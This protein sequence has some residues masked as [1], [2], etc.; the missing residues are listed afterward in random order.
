VPRA[1]YLPHPFQV[2]QGDG[3]ILIEFSFTCRPSRYS[4]K[5]EPNTSSIVV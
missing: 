4:C 5:P 1:T 2:I 3:Y